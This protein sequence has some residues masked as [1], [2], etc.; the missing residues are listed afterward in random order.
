MQQPHADPNRDEDP[1]HDQP[2]RTG[3]VAEHRSEGVPEEEPNRDKRCRPQARGEEIQPQETL[4][5]DGAETKRKG[6]KVA[7]TVDKAERQDE[8]G[9]VAL[10]PV[11]R[12]IDPVPPP[13][14]TVEQANP[15]LAA[16]PE[17]ALIAREAP[18]PSSYEEQKRIDQ[19]LRRGEAGKQD[20]G[21][22]FEKRPNEGDRVEAGP[23]I[24]NKLID[25]HPGPFPPP[26]PP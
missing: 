5:F 22:A 18:E 24:G 14:E 20:N 7:Y 2:E 12:R 9:V 8:A 17:I 3:D 19:P 21:L 23:V 4:P 11:Q 26:P 13:R 6:R 15:E 25:I 1:E 16:Q 10:Q